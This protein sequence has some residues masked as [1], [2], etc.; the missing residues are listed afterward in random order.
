M[1]LI[2][3]IPVPAMIGSSHGCE[4]VGDFWDDDNLELDKHDT[5]IMTMI[6]Q[7]GMQRLV[8]TNE[9]RENIGTTR[10][11]TYA[12]FISNRSSVLRSCF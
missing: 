12:E 2:P 8:P 11:C 9:K 10:I 7:I 5:S 3:V 6:V 1:V 4:R